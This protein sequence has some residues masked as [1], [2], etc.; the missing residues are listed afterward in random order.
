MNAPK[1]IRST[2]APEISAT[3]MMQNVVWN[4]K[5]TRCG[6]VVPSRGTKS[7]PCRNALP[8]PPIRSPV[9]SN[10]SEYPTAAHVT[11]AIAIAATD[12]MNVL[13]V[14]FERTRPA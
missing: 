13:S 9:P 3:V 5:K 14:F 10:A 2:T 1:R 4:A 8:S 12:I 11:V 7:T 6:I